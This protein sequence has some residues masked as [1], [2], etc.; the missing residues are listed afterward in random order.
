[1]CTKISVTNAPAIVP[2]ALPNGKNRPTKH[3][4]LLL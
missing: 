2:L 4:V 3:E 1:M